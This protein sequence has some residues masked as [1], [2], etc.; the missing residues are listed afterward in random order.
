MRVIPLLFCIAQA[1]APTVQA[2]DLWS[3]DDLKALCNSLEPVTPSTVKQSLG[4]YQAI[5][6]NADRVPPASLRRVK[7]T[8]IEPLLTLA[9][10]HHWGALE[11]FS[12]PA[13]ADSKGCALLLDRGTL[14]E[15]HKHFDLHAVW[16][17]AATLADDASKT[18]PMNYM[19]VGSGRLVVGYPRAATVA[20]AD[21]EATSGNYDYVPYFSAR[22]ENSAHGRGLFDIRAL[23]DPRGEFGAF[24]GPYGAQIQQLTLNE[25]DIMVKFTLGLDQER[26]ARNVAINARGWVADAR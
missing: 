23:S 22:I 6:H 10:Q 19:I 17:I 3:P 1:L 26:R 13:F 4:P 24:T 18:L 8:D 12:Q 25:G 14:A 20:I 16:Q 21:G 5:L 9:A 15:V 11:V 7:F 2:Q